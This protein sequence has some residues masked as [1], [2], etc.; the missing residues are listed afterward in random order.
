MIVAKTKK[1]FNILANIFI[2]LIKFL[3]W[4]YKKSIIQAGSLIIQ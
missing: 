3:S 1:F 2:S 4:K